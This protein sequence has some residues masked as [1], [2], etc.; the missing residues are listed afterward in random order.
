[1]NE[2][3]KEPGC[4]SLEYTTDFNVLEA[5]VNLKDGK[6]APDRS[7]HF[8]AY[9]QCEPFIPDMVLLTET[10]VLPKVNWFDVQHEYLISELDELM[11][12]KVLYVPQNAVFEELEARGLQQVISNLFERDYR[13]LLIA[14]L[15][16]PDKYTTLLRKM[17][18]IERNT[19]FGNPWLGGASKISH[20]LEN[21]NVRDVYK[22]LMSYSFQ[23]DL[24]PT[25]LSQALASSIP[26]TQEGYYYPKEIVY[27]R[28][29]KE[30]ATDGLDIIRNSLKKEKGEEAKTA[31]DVLVETLGKVSDKVFG[32]SLQYRARID[33]PYTLPI[34]LKEIDDGKG[35]KQMYD[36]MLEKRQ[37]LRPLRR[38][39]V[40]YD[41]ALAEHGHGKQ[42]LKCEREL[43]KVSS[44]IIEEY[45]VPPLEQN[46]FNYD[47]ITNDAITIAQIPC[48]PQK[49]KDII[50]P[51]I[52]PLIDAVDRVVYPHRFYMK[53][54][55]TAFLNDDMKILLKH[56][57]PDEGKKFFEVLRYYSTLT[58]KA[59]E[60]AQIGVR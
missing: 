45:K 11:D 47:N 40:K 51:K 54:V 60:V 50:L 26:T 20:W 44:R 53:S 36:V 55:G 8:W 59:K 33:L 2:E 15:S 28:F 42:T 46:V 56:K 13:N 17:G 6:I 38:W 14:V 21:I 43:Q 27:S 37:E 4:I 58:D 31:Y 35:P 30:A 18:L 3:V 16:N 29:I 52:T 34:I 19:A 22:V 10:I 12:S 24:C 23:K 57:F 25:G 9:L 5:L 39:I 49:I 41:T 48:E 1:M 32:S 7:K